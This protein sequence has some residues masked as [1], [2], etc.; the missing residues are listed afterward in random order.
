[1]FEIMEVE[2]SACYDNTHHYSYGYIR[3]TLLLGTHFK[4]VLWHGISV[5]I[6]KQI[7]ISNEFC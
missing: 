2:N 6:Q 3:K 1:M 4:E 5:F 7:T